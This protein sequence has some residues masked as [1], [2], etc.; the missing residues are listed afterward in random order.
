MP[1]A[2]LWRETT[3]SRTAGQTEMAATFMLAYIRAAAITSLQSRSHSASTRRSAEGLRGLPPFTLTPQVVHPTVCQQGEAWWEIHYQGDH[4][5]SLSG[6]KQRPRSKW[7]WSTVM[8]VSLPNRTSSGRTRCH[9]ERQPGVDNHEDWEGSLH[10]SDE[11]YYLKFLMVK[12]RSIGQRNGSKEFVWDLKDPQA[13]EHQVRISIVK[14][15]C[16]VSWLNIV[17]IVVNPSDNSPY[18]MWTFKNL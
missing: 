3:A 15:F 16:K 4:Y 1:V 7:Q 5:C 9:Q 11:R 18:Q 10:V 12:G 14:I 6:C 17:Q 8:L 2:F 13:N